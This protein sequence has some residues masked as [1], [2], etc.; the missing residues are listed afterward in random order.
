MIKE[1]VKR[2]ISDFLDGELPSTA[3]DKLFEHSETAAENLEYLQTLRLIKRCAGEL[4][5]TSPENLKSSVLSVVAKTVRMK[6]KSNIFTAL[7]VSLAAI[8]AIAV[9]WAVFFPV[10]SGD[11]GGTASK[12]SSVVSNSSATSVSSDTHTSALPSE[13]SSD[14]SSETQSS[15]VNSYDYS[16]YLPYGIDEY[17]PQE[18]RGEKYSYVIVARGEFL[19]TM[20]YSSPSSYM[21]VFNQPGETAVLL[22]AVDYENMTKVLGQFNF[23]INDTVTDETFA[24]ISSQAKMG[25]VFIRN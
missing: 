23:Y 21:L 24:G 25:I 13:S 14:A 4:V 18:Y 3:Q 10:K 12:P 1:Y 17:L 9:I 19:A 7:W 11:S 22:C 6:R 15:D 5:E 20:M 2:D 16:Q 8:L